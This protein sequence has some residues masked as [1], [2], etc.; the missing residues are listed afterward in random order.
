MA[1]TAKLDRH[2][3]DELANDPAGSQLYLRQKELAMGKFRNHVTQVELLNFDKVLK[4]DK[5]PEDCLTSYFFGIRVNENEADDE[6]RGKQK[7]TGNKIPPKFG[8]A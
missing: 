3:L 4:N 1:S 5:N 6:N 7:Q 8:Y 2:P